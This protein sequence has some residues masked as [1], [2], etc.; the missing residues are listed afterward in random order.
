M[1]KPPKQNEQK[2]LV[3]LDTHAILH[4]AY[5]AVPDF[6]SS[7]GVP[8][9]ALYGLLNM[10]LKMLTDLKPDYVIACYD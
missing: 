9:G 6:T 1:A 8:T 7:L 10:F 2:T 5:H 3:L 4:R